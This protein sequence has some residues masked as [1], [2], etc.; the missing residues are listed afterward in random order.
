MRG[1]EDSDRTDHLT[2][3]AGTGCPGTKDTIRMSLKARELGADVLSIIC[4]Y[5]AAANQME[6]YGHYT[7]V[8]KAVDLPI[9][10]YNI[11]P[12]AGNKI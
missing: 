2:V 1:S 5:F 9:V 12:R 4:P 10:I 3:Y 8:A 7:A 11:P 6:I